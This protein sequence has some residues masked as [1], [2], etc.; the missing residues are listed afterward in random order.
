M[1]HT[2][3]PTLRLTPVGQTMTSP[4]PAVA[5]R[6]AGALAVYAGLLGG[7]A[8]VCGWPV[9]WQ[10]LAVGAASAVF[11]VWCAM[12]RSRR[13]CLPALLVLLCVAWCLLLPQT[14]DSAA[15]LWNGALSCLQRLTGRI[16]LPLTY[17]DADALW[18]AIPACGALGALLGSLAVYAPA[19]GVVLAAACGILSAAAGQGGIWLAV[20]CLG[21]ALLCL[22]HRKSCRTA[23]TVSLYTA[24]LLVLLAAIAAGVVTLSGLTSQLDT[25]AADRAIREKVHALRYESAQQALP[26]GDLRKTVTLSDRPMLDVTL[27]QPET[28]YLRSFIGQRYTRDGWEELSADSLSSQTEDVYWLQSSGFFSQTQL[29]TLASLLK[30]ETPQLQVEIS[31]SGACRRYAVIPYELSDAALCDARQLRDTLPAGGKHYR[32]TASGNLTARAYELLD[33]LSQHLDDPAFQDYLAQET[34]YRRT[35]YDNYLTVPEDTQKVLASFLG[36]PPASITSY[37]A[38]SRVLSCL[39]ST[40]EYDAQ[41]TLLPADGD[42]VS[43]LLKEGG[44]GSAVG[45]ASAAVLMLRYYGIPA[46]YAEGYLITPAM[47]SGKSGETTL[48]LTGENAH[49]WAEYYEDGVGWIPF[50]T[51]APYLDVMPQS[52]WRWFQPDDKSD[53]TGGQSQQGGDGQNSTVRHSTVETVEKPSDEPQV[54]TL[55]KELTTTLRHTLSQRH[56]GR[57][58][59]LLLLLALILAL[60]VLILRRRRA[61]RRRRAAFD[62]PDPAQGTTALFAYAM[63]LMWRSGLRRE[64]RSLLEQNDAVAKWMGRPVDFLPLA[65][66]NAEA[67]CSTHPIPET[68]RQTMRQFAADTVKTFRRKLKPWQKLYQK[69]IRCMY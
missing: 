7:L 67:R 4:L 53:M 38:K 63:E 60:L 28:L 22:G 17:Q 2:S 26:E 13:A 55:W 1:K 39:K 23:P 18:A 6:S 10:A 64:N 35:V 40:V 34:A 14:A 30:L 61:C 51:T 46:R 15:G 9:V 54:I 58:M 16:F 12:G 25:T 56:V 21:A 37:E 62:D 31:A 49:A 8:A 33:G 11:A 29:S 52:D 19:A 57:W 43:V 47:V 24:A 65:R 27:S 36:T 50:E 59:L 42:P 5:E 44:Q 69:W 32:Y 20:L 66:L 48:T 3:S 41:A 45:Y 68:Q